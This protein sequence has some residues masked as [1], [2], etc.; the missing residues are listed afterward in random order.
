MLIYVVLWKL[1]KE[2]CDLQEIRKTRCCVANP[3]SDV[4]VERTLK[5]HVT[6]K[7]QECRRDSQKP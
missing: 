3:K 7:K 4:L 6:R 5:G 1:F 2:M